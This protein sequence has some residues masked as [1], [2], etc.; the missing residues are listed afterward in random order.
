ML[1]PAATNPMLAKML[2][3]FVPVLSF[4]LELVKEII[5]KTFITCN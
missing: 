1:D 4:R 2:G 3:E 5:T